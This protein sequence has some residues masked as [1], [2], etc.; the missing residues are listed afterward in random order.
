MKKAIIMLVTLYLF[1]SSSFLFS[2]QFKKNEI[3]DFTISFV[4][5]F[6][7]L[8]NNSIIKYASNSSSDE[9]NV[10]SKNKKLFLG[11]TI[12]FGTGA[13]TFLVLGIILGS[14]Y[15]SVPYGIEYERGQN[16]NT[17]VQN[18]ERAAYPL[19]AGTICA[20]SL[21]GFT[22]VLAI[23]TFILYVIATDLFGIEKGNSNKKKAMLEIKPSDNKLDVLVRVAIN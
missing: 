14:V 18:W 15:S 5:K 17:G 11:L 3:N 9:D 2:T 10:L 20:W 4:E 13:C 7:T 12:A 6:E 23:A 8:S 1:I 21:F 22:G 16:N 19:L